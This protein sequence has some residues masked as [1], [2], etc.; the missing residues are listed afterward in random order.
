ML[1]NTYAQKSLLV[2][3][4]KFV[5]VSQDIALNYAFMDSISWY[6]IYYVF[7]YSHS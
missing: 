5:S 7:L 6:L 4:K 1:V 2:R 3:N